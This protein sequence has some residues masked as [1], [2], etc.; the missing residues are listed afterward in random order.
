MSKE[1]TLKSIALLLKRAKADATRASESKRKLYEFIEEHIADLSEYSTH[2]ENADTLD[3]AISCYIDYNEYTA[4]GL[5]KEIEEA[6][7][8]EQRT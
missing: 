4:E 2:A 1:S 7:D 8:N 5:L 6:I 3:E